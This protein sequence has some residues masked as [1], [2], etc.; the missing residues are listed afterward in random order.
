MILVICEVTSMLS[1]CAQI[2]AIRLCRSS[3]SEYP[4]S[5]L[6]DRNDA[7][8]TSEIT[9]SCVVN[10]PESAR[11]VSFFVST[12]DSVALNYRAVI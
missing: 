3:S 7:Y 6:V 12:S 11:E 5:V 8:V 4:S 1:G 10:P 9:P 2:P